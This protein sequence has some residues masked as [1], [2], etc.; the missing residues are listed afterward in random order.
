MVAYEN[1]S[2][3]WCIGTQWWSLSSKPVMVCCQSAFG[4]LNQCVGIMKHLFAP[5]SILLSWWNCPCIKEVKVL[6]GSVELIMYWR[7]SEK[8]FSNLIARGISTT[9][10]RLEMM[11]ITKIQ[12]FNKRGTK[13]FKKEQYKKWQQKGENH[14]DNYL[15]DFARTQVR[16][17][18]SGSTIM[19]A[20][21]RAWDMK[22][23]GKK[24]KVK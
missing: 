4:R 1:V 23:T 2:L 22:P 16:T 11:Q 12:T 10:C 8:M 9:S 21:Q 3:L 14:L 7:P 5:I 17:P 18:T 19:G 24:S 6:R 20:G 13:K 15:T